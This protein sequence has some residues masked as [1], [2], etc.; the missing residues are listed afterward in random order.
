METNE[1]TTSVVNL[2]F[3]SRKYTSVD[4]VT[5]EITTFKARFIRVNVSDD[6]VGYDKDGNEVTKTYFDMQLGKF[7]NDIVSAN[8]DCAV[9]AN[10]VKKTE[11]DAD[12]RDYC[13]AF[14]LIMKNAQI[15]VNRVFHAKD[16]EEI[17]AD[18]TVR[19]YD[20]DCFT[21]HITD[22]ELT[23]AIRTKFAEARAE[24]LRQ[25]IFAGL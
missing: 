22:V 13:S 2:S 16:S 10:G 19:H 14:S 15:T 3:W 5:G 21:N 12:K 6:I 20:R 18:G 9:I 23:E 4:E 17:D 7:V 8:A 25:A 1:I 24:R 11:P